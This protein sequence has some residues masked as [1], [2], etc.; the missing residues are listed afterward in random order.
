MLLLDWLIHAFHVQSGVAGRRVAMN[1]IQGSREQLKELLLSLASGDAA[2]ASK[3]AWLVEEDH[4]IHHFRRQHPS[5]AKVHEIA[6]RLGISG[7]SKMPENELIVEIL[8]LAPEMDEQIE[9]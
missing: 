3:Q 9:L 6:A 7:R 5:R 8:S 2:L 1:V 4:P